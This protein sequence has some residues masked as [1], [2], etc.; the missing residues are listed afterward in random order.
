MRVEQL[1]KDLGEEILK[2]WKSEGI[3]ELRPAQVKALKAGVLRG[4]N[5]LV[6]TPTASG[7]TLI[8]ELA[9]IK[10][11]EKGKQVVYI[12]PLIA[13]AR[14]KYECFKNR[15]KGIF[16]VALSVG[17]FDSSDP[18]LEDYE[19][20]VCTAEKL[21]SLARHRAPWLKKVGLVI[22]D[23]IHLLNDPGRGPVLEILITMLRTLLSEAQVLALSATIGNEEELAKWLNASLVKD[24]WRPVPLRK[25]ILLEDK[26]F[27][28]R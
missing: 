2:R 13:L 4:E 12:V 20:I 16:K 22:I 7:K 19:L 14:E 6:S 17:D 1:E 21:D 8:A 15:Y 23:E 3:E 25:G 11:I 27:F 18:F 28:D 24:E 5:L 9:S 10:A 26:I